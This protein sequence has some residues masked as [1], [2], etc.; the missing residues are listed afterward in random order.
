MQIFVGRLQREV[1]EAHL[2]GAGCACAAMHITINA[3]TQ[4]TKHGTGSVSRR[5]MVIQLFMLTF[6]EGQPQ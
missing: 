1:G 3:A 5:V 6:R 2:D 4:S